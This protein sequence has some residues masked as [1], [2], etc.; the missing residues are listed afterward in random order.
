MAQYKIPLLVPDLPSADELLPYLR[1]IDENR[2]YTNF[3]P[4]VC[5]YESQL[6][7]WIKSLSKSE[8]H[9]VTLNTGTAALELGLTALNLKPGSRVLVPA[10]TFPATATA[11]KRAG[12][13]PVLTDVDPSSWL[14]T[15]EIAR[16]VA[17]RTRIDAVLPVSTFGVLQ[18]VDQWD[19]FTGDTGLPVLIDGA[20][21]LATQGIGKTTA[22]A[23]SLNATK[24]LGVGEGG[25]VATAD[26]ALAERIRIHSNFGFDQGCI[27]MV[28]GTNAKLSE[29][30]AAVGLAQ[31]DRK[32]QVM[33]R[34]RNVAD[35]YLGRLADVDDITLQDNWRGGVR[36]VLPLL[37]ESKTTAQVVCE[38]LAKQ[39][40][41]TRQWYSPPLTEHPAFTN[42][43]AVAADGNQEI[44][45]CYRLS[46]HMFGLPFHTS[47]TDEE[48]DE[49]SAECLN[50]IGA[51]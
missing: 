6:A 28:G 31:M 24:P 23:Y 4:L 10:F 46:R 15:P 27:S 37:L 26:A 7:G 25:L 18:A 47:L 13:V 36:F 3:G 32:E 30:H 33:N 45:F 48:I 2:W 44:R 29:Y 39:G 40:I 34:Y 11:V 41:E 22:V 35:K 38:K 17:T 50:A 9:V 12:H 14:L 51:G 49:V 20:A 5:E 42:A 19:Q 1:R 21:A 16:S 43:Q 8:T